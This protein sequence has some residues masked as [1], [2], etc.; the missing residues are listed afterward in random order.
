M[1]GY[2]Q[3]DLFCCSP[4]HPHG[5]QHHFSLVTRFWLPTLSRSRWISSLSPALAKDKDDG[6]RYRAVSHPY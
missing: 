6:D 2:K 1:P 4:P 5:V 3:T